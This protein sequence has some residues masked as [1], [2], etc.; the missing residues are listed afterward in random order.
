MPGSDQFSGRECA[1]SNQAVGGGC[2]DFCQFTEFFEG[3]VFSVFH[4]ESPFVDD[5]DYEYV[6]A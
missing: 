3:H 5:C 6:D 4:A 1:V 2:A